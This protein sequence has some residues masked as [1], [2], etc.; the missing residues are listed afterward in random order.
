MNK[1]IIFGTIRK[2]NYLIWLLLLIFFA[3][4][5]TYFYDRTKNNQIIY[6]NKLLNNIYLGNSI[7]NITNQLSPRYINLEYIVK[8]S[9]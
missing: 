1:K 4:F 3:V 2:F 8:E 9:Y 7:K 5:V 6:F